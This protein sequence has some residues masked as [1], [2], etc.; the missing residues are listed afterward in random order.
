MEASLHTDQDKFSRILAENGD[1]LIKIS[2]NNEKPVK[3]LNGNDLWKLVVKF[4]DIDEKVNDFY[5]NKQNLS[6]LDRDKMRP[7]HEYCKK[8]KFS[9]KTQESE[10]EV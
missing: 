3:S 2:K 4:K 5:K 9:Q 1:T 8:L 10:K 6:S 7:F